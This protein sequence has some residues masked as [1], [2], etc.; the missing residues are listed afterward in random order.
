MLKTIPGLTDSSVEF[1]V[2]DNELKFLQN[3][4]VCKFEDLS[5]A[6][7]DILREEM[8]V[9]KNVIRALNLMHPE[10]QEL[11]LQQ[12]A[13]C[14]LGGF[15]FQPDIKNGKVQDGEYWPCPKHGNCP[16][17]G[18]LCKLPKVNDVRLTKQDVL[19]MQLSTTEKTN[20]AI[21]SDLDLAMGSFHKAKR[22]IHNLLK[23]Q[24][25]QGITL[26]CTYLNLI[27]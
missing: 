9:E 7:K 15:D 13:L 22:A 24:T 16:H 23:V 18:V 17:E 27:E 10:N 1:F 8:Y 3:G 21:A 5:A 20:E 14:R 6:V 26:I 2:V 4:Q 19:L 12:F 25:K 11:Q